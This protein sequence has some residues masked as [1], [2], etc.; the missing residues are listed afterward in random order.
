MVQAT[1]AQP[2]FPLPLISLMN[3]SV[4]FNLENERD[5]NGLGMTN[6]DETWEM[7]S[8]WFL[9][10]LF[11]HNLLVP[12]IIKPV[13]QLAKDWWCTEIFAA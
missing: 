6:Q 3:V 7:T 2:E 5:R 8:I 4:R 12:K 9:S 13:D 10:I 1:A 11:L